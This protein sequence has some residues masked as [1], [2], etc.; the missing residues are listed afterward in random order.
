[1]F[2][3]S[4]DMEYEDEN[5]APVSTREMRPPEKTS[6]RSA[7][8]IFGP[9]LKLNG[10][11]WTEGEIQFDGKIKGSIRSGTLIV[12]KDA[13]IEGD[14]IANTVTVR[15]RTKGS[16][17]A[18]KVE[19]LGS[20]HVEGDILHTDLTVESGA[21]FEGGCRHAEDPFAKQSKSGSPKSQR[22]Q[23]E[24]RSSSSASQEVLPPAG[25]APVKSVA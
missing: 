18:R 19:L 22:A 10:D 4:R 5:E 7:P 25:N 3:K 15:G 21:F 14:I 23:S 17:R 1:M 12:G 8:S 9:D 24:P 16:L 11:L 6:G 13:E 2:N 20:C